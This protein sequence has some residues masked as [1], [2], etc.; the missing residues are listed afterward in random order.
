MANNWP[1]GGE[2]PLSKTEKWIVGIAGVVLI[3][4]GVGYAVMV[5]VSAFGLHPPLGVVIVIWVVALAAALVWVQP[6]NQVAPVDR[7]RR[8]G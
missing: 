8:C 1:D 2:T 3:A 6:W 5:L 4:G 7:S